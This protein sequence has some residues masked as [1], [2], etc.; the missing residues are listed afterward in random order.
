MFTKERRSNIMYALLALLFSFVLFFYANGSNLQN[1]FTTTPN[2][3]EETLEDVP[4]Q[5]KYN[6]DKYFIQGYQPTVNVDLR[7]INRIQLDAETNEETRNF[8]VVADLTSLSEGTHDVMLEVQNMSNSVKATISPQIFTVT[9]EK[10]VA[11]EFPVEVDFSEENLQD[12]FRLD[13]ITS[14]PNKVTVTTGEQTA[15]EISKVIADVSSLQGI[16][17]NQTQ[18]VPV[19]AV[20]K[21][22]DILQTT[23]Q[24]EEVQVEAIVSAPEKEVSLF[25]SQQGTTPNGISHF[26]YVLD[27][28]KATISGSQELIDSLSSIGVPVDVSTIR[29]KT[30]QVVTIPVPDGVISHPQE[31]TIEITPVFLDSSEERPS[32]TI[33]STSSSVSGAES[34]E[35]IP[36]SETT[37]SASTTPEVSESG[38]VEETIQSSSSQEQETE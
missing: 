32:E 7:S 36:S 24:P 38:N 5:I 9:I 30:T 15:E 4:V 10:K 27:Q 19:H 33:P 35:P 22:G 28:T 14:I 25:A 37:T 20:N 31:V 23:I 8:R 2:M 1:T 3:F 16:T 18:K 26:N 11:K 12:G 13:K 34:T 29:E 6:Q 21:N 17:S